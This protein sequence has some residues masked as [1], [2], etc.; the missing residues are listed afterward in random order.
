[1]NA[2]RMNNARYK[3]SQMRYGIYSLCLGTHI[4]VYVILHMDKRHVSI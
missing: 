3:W 1:M 4:K 2:V